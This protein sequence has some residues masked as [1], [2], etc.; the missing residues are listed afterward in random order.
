MSLGWG[1]CGGD[2]EGVELV[3]FVEMWVVE[4]R[5]GWWGDSYFEREKERPEPP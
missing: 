1:L 3:G 4:T 2:V 5:Q